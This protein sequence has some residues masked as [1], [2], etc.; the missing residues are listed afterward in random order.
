MRNKNGGFTLIELMIVVAIIAILAM[1][2]IPSYN[3][4]VQKSRRADGRALLQAAQL[5]EEKF[6]LN[7]EAYGASADF[8]DA[9]F[10]RVCLAVNNCPSPNGH[11]TLTATG[12]TASGYTLTATA[13]GSQTKDTACSALTITQA[14]TGVTYGPAGCWSK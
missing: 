4:Y 7:H 8:G 6:R 5:A 14:T 11:Y 10:A 9:A 2:A 3:S 1:I 13:Q 12:N